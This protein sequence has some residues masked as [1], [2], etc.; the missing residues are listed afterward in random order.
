MEERLISKHKD[1]FTLFFLTL[2]LSVDNMDLISH[3]I[4]CL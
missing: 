2:L 4:V 3:K 1:N